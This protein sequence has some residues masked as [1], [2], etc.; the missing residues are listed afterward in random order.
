[1]APTKKNKTGLKLNSKIKNVKT[2]SDWYRMCD[3]YKTNSFEIKSKIKWLASDW[4]SSKFKG[5]ES[6]RKSFE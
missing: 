6:E 4:T 1:M 2:C 5:T 3:D